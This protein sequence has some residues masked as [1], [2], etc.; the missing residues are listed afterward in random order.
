MIDITNQSQLVALLCKLS[1]K[2][3]PRFGIMTPHHMVEHLAFSVQFSN[4]KLPQKLYVTPEKARAIKQFILG[5]GEHPIGFKSPVLGDGLEALVTPDLPAAIQYLG[6]E[7]ASFDQYFAEH[8]TVAPTNPMLGE[9]THSEW[10]RFHNKH[11]SHHL[12]QF[13]LLSA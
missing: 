2:D 10:I 5:D 7:L 9:L 13:G 6:T 4:G 3:V 1:Q 12:K 8:P 11:F